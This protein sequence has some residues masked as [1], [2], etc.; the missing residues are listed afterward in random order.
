MSTL[1]EFSPDEMLHAYLDQ[2]LTIDQEQHFYSLLA[3][4]SELSG[5][6]RHM[7][8]LRS[9]TLRSG[10]A[11]APPATGAAG[12]GA[13]SPP[14]WL[15]FAGW[16]WHLDGAT[17]IEGSAAAGAMISWR[18]GLQLLPNYDGNRS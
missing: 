5:K 11:V 18:K 17:S 12:M 13:G 3:S 15:V 16:S 4:D 9:E 8:A 6:L 14:R 10:G 1:Y 7:R 2:D